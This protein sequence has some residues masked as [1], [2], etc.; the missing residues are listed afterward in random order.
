MYGTNMEALLIRHEK[1]TDELGNTMEVKLWKIPPAADKPHGFKY[2][3]VYIVAGQ[4]VIGYDNGEGKGDHRHYGDKEEPYGFVSIRQLA[5]DFLTDVENFKKE[6]MMKVKKMNIGIRDFR[7]ALNDFVVAGEALAQGDA[8][9][10]GERVSFVS[11]EAFRKALTPRRLELL[12]VVKTARPDSLN[13]LAGLLR[14]NIKNVANDVKFLVQV[15]LLE[16]RRE[17]NRLA[18]KVVYDEIDLRIAV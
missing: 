11:I 6:R 14:R 10:E 12:H 16:T 2:S 13:Q 5:D 9:P 4:R 8:V 3:L 17:D 15:G 1:V 7:T 18:P